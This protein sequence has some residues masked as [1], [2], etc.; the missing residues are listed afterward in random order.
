MCI[1]RVLENLLNMLL[2]MAKTL[3]IPLVTAG[4]QCFS[5]G[6]F[7]VGLNPAVFSLYT[8]TPNFLSRDQG[9]GI[10]EAD[11]KTVNSK[12]VFML[13]KGSAMDKIIS[14][15]EMSDWICTKRMH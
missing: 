4:C 7:P 6:K 11:A 10:F 3:A 2:Q 13:L 5:G 15:A 8:D 14:A 1:D 12:S 9:L